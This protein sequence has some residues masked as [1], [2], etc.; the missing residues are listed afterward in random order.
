M[1]IRPVHW[2]EGMF[3]RPQHFQVADRHAREALRASEDWF[4]PFDWGLR[5]VEFDRDAVGNYVLSLRACE[6][7]LDRKSVV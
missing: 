6:A 4:Q 7:R 5:S 3:L 1:P 2:Y